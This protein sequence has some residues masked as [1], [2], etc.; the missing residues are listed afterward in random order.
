MSASSQQVIVRTYQEVSLARAEQRF[1]E[2][3]DRLGREG[4]EVSRVISN[5]SESVLSWWAWPAAKVALV[6]TYVH[7]H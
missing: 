2:D 6:V 7:R 1:R 4:Y 3:A 5:R